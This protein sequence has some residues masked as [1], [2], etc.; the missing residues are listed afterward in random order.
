MNL[1]YSKLGIAN[2]DVI[3]T[4]FKNYKVQFLIKYIN[5]E[6]IINLN[7]NSIDNKTNYIKNMEFR[8]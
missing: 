8:I 5:I 7:L 3:I 6:N 2:L 1:Y 4:L